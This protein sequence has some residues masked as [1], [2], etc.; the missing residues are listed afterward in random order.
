[1][2]N[3]FF[4]NIGERA[5]APPPAIRHQPWRRLAQAFQS[6]ARL[7]KLLPTG[8]ILAFQVLAPLFTNGGACSSAPSLA[9]SSASP[10][11]SATVGGRRGVA[12]TT[13]GG[14]GVSD[15]VGSGPWYTFW[16]QRLCSPLPLS[17]TLS[18]L[19]T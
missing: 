2:T 7:A 5:A 3:N 18:D 16:H 17:I 6:S 11:A 8:T 12:A 13:G 9:S 1:M 15:K 19:R 14:G 4:I 10:T